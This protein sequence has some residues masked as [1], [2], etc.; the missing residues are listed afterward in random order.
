MIWFSSL[1]FAV[2]DW[3]Y[4][5]NCRN[6][7]VEIHENSTRS[8]KK[9]YINY[10]LDLFSHPWRLYN[11]V[12]LRIVSRSYRL[13]R[14][15]SRCTVFPFLFLSRHDARGR[16]P[17]FVSV[18]V[19]RT[20][21]ARTRVKKRPHVRRDMH[22]H[23]CT[24]AILEIAVCFPPGG[25]RTR[26][27]RSY[28]P[29][30]SRYIFSAGALKNARPSKHPPRLLAGPVYQ[31]RSRLVRIH[32]V[33]R[34]V[35]VRKVNRWFRLTLFISGRAMIYAGLVPELSRLISPWRTA[36]FS[37]IAHELRADKN[38]KVSRN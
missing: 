31:A 29:A 37:R 16:V 34:F 25:D 12:A 26:D 22:N 32:R 11:N 2:F 7:R 10:I 14:G 9:T 21:R 15:S 17:S 1:H 27:L 4:W 13:D 5:W 36:I 28:T 38:G 19:E 33:A 3:S 30:V 18:T 20:L 6:S 23:G 24:V 8:I 35:A